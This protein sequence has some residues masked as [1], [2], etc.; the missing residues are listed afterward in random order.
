MTHKH[1]EF[2][3]AIANGESLVDWECSFSNDDEKW[4]PASLCLTNIIFHPEIF[5]VRRK[6]A[7]HVVNGFTVP[8]PLRVAPAEQTSYFVSAFTAKLFYCSACWVNDDIDKRWLDR[9]LVHL[10]KEAAIAN[11]KAMCGINPESKDE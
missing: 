7:T 11:A 4:A 6:Q 5:K 2:F 8:A 1:A 10:T 9:G 3:N